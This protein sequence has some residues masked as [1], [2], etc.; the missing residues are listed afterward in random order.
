VRLFIYEYTCAQPAEPGAAKLHSEGQAMLAAVVEDFSR[1]PGVEVATLL[2]SLQSLTLPASC[3]ACSFPGERGE[4]AVFRPLAAWADFTLV[5]AP[6]LD[7]LLEERCRWVLESG[8]RLLGPTPEAVR[9]TADKLAL[10]KHWRR[11]GVP[12][13]LTCRPCKCALPYPVVC[14]LRHGAGSLGTTLARDAAEQAELVKRPGEWVI[15]SLV[16][17][18]PASLA[19]LIGPAEITPLLPAWQHLD[20]SFRYLGG[21]A[22]IPAKLAERVQRLAQRAVE[23]VPGLL[24]YVGV[25]VILGDAEEGSGD[26]ALEINP[27]LTT[28]YVGL[29]RLA[30]G[31][32]AEA[33]LQCVQGKTPRLTWQP[34][35]LRWSAD[36]E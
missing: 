30:Q 29:R 12:T 25:D 18:R 23:C 27:R 31:N 26:V 32:L 20:S 4:Q 19:L 24:G 3:F 11:Q 21:E 9:L 8:G 34:G 6:E 1:I 13:P 7:G 33:M 2:A 5:I 22:P 14:K 36:A 10:A 28:S 15:Q 16:P 17:G 35:P